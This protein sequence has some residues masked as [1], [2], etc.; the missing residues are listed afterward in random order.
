MTRSFDPGLG[1]QSRAL[2]RWRD[3][4]AALLSFG[5]TGAGFLI[6]EVPF[7]TAYL[8]FLAALL[9]GND[10]SGAR[11]LRFALVC[12]HFGWVAILSATG[13]IGLGLSPFAVVPGAL[14]AVGFAGLLYA[15]FGLALPTLVLSIMPL[16]H[17]SPLLVTGA[18]LPGTGLWGLAALLLLAWLI[19]GQSSP[20]RRIG[21]VGVLAV[22]LVGWDTF[23]QARPTTRASEF[24][25][26]RL[27][28]VPAITRR[29][30]WTAMLD[31]A[32]HGD[33]LI[34]GENIFGADD[35]AA[36]SWWCRELAER[37]VSAW[38]GVL[39]EGDVAEVWRFDD[40]TCPEGTP[41]YRSRTGVPLV[42][43]TWWRA[44][45]PVPVSGELAEAPA[46]HWL[47]CFEAFSLRRWVDLGLEVNGTGA[48][49][50]SVV[51][52]SNDRWTKPFP[53]PAL[54]RKV[55]KQFER[56]L[57][58]DVVHADTGQTVLVRAR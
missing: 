8:P 12:G 50:R 25:E 14:L 10:V 23:Y 32:E 58:V 5:A 49:A 2:E 37:D 55:S 24:D 54:R 3:L 48:K 39:G 26:V 17:A 11:V 16:F 34:L 29:A 6:E 57:G 51:I 43:E 33:T 20:R 35:W 30:E 47:I 45:A 44:T 27:Q 53:V 31:Q 40:A 41:V 36:R 21:Q 15:W 18:L 38:I 42:T 28:P 9:F 1:G 19:E 46:P 52:L 22:L 7:A 4:G 13:L 56:L